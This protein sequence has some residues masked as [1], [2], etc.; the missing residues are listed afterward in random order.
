MV[1]ARTDCHARRLLQNC[2]MINHHHDQN[3][4][5]YLETKLSYALINDHPGGRGTI[6]GSPRSFA[7][8]R[9]KSPLPKTKI[10]KKLLTPL[11]WG[12]TSVLCQ[13]IRGNISKELYRRNR[14][15]LPK[16]IG[17]T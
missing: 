12:Q 10:H 4:D 3:Y 14:S 9:Y 5:I 8:R 13:V 6:P 17:D 11:H 7:Q 15:F 2:A 16:N 1:I